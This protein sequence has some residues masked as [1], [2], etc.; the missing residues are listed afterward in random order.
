LKMLK[1]RV[2]GVEKAGTKVL[3]LRGVPKRSGGVGCSLCNL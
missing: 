2:Q 3:P 1:F